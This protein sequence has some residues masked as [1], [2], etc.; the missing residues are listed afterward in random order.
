MINAAGKAG[1]NQ[2]NAS[3]KKP[4]QQP[5]TNSGT[6]SQSVTPTQN[7]SKPNQQNKPTGQVQTQQELVVKTRLMHRQRRPANNPTQ[8]QV[9]L[10]KVQRQHKTRLNLHNKISQQDK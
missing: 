10:H 4:S 8:I 3:T 1:Q 9:L 5:N 2:T 7:P 6:N